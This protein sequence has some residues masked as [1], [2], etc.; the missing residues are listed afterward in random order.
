MSN[1]VQLENLSNENLRKWLASQIALVD[2]MDECSKCG[3]PRLLH[4]DYVLHRDATCTRGMEVSNILRESWKAYIQRV[5]PILKI[6]QE[7]SKKEIEQG[8]FLKG[9]EKLVASNSEMIASNDENMK[10]FFQTIKKR[11][12]SPS[13]HSSPSPRPA[14]LTK[15]AKVPSWTKDM[16]LE[17]YVKQLTTLQQINEDIA[18][19]AKYH[20]LIEDLKKNKEIKGLKKF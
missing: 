18:E 17:T 8:A 12:H 14:K 10:S 19:F 13:N 6:M 7:E 9:L 3:Y 1:I 4:K 2:W 11:E 20:E 5:K 16:S 15:P